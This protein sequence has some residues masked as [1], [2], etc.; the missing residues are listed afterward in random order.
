[1]PDDIEAPY[2]AG[3]AFLSPPVRGPPDGIAGCA[4][5]RAIRA[6]FR[7]RSTG[8]SAKINKVS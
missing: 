7:T 6:E 3:R 2:G 8:K 4:D 1:M 5:F